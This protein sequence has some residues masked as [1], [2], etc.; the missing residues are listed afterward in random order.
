[1]APSFLADLR[2][3][4]KTSFS[5]ST[6]ASDAS[7]GNKPN[8]RSRSHTPA[9][10]GNGASSPPLTESQSMNTINTPPVPPRP[11]MTSNSSRNRWSMSGLSGLGALSRTSSLPVSQ[12]SPRILS[13]TDNSWVSSSCLS[14][15]GMES[16]PDLTMLEVRGLSL[17]NK[18]FCAH[19]HR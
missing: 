2:K 7:N 11:I 18:C 19:C 12:Y 10:N 16:E 3:R 9:L 15:P 1:M 6:E 8:S 4:S 5:R 17:A 14:T 13:I